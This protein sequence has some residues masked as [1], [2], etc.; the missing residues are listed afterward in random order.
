MSRTAEIFAHEQFELREDAGALDSPAFRPIRSKSPVLSAQAQSRLEDLSVPD[1][2]YGWVIV[3]A[4]AVITFWF[5]GTSYSWGV[6][7]KA[8]VDEGISKT[9]TLSFVGGL[10]PMCISL[11]ALFN[12]R[13][14]RAI[15][16][17]WVALLGILF[18]G[19]GEILSGFA[20]HSV[21]G[22]FATIGVISGIGTRYIPSFDPQLH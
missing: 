5:V 19:S 15:G 2:G 13:M 4:C 16:A 20:M 11:L 14:V 7:Q 12:A 3:S 9:S 17:R 8:L 22:L 10:T 6:I 1:G 18:L 21:G